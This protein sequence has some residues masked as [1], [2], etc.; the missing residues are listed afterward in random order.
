MKTPEIDNQYSTSPCGHNIEQAL[1]AAG[2]DLHHLK[3][4]DLGALE[5]IH[6]SVLADPAATPTRPP[7]PLGRR[8][9]VSTG[10]LVPRRTGSG[11]AK[12]AFVLGLLYAAV[13]AYWGLGGTWLLATVGGALQSQ[14]RAGT[15][16]VVLAV[17][18]AVVLKMVAA[19]LP[20]LALRRVTSPGG[21]RAVG[22]L[23]WIEA[24]ILTV[25]GLV[26]TAVGMLVQAGT[27]HP[28]AGADHRA[29]AW[30]AYL[31]DPWFLVWGL[32]VAIALW[33]GRHTHGQVQ[34]QSGTLGYRQKSETAR[35]A[36]G[37]V[38]RRGGDT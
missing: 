13:S 38:L 34:A 6:T 9:P 29:S 5:D 16:I 27:I 30:H 17:W 10:W 14:G 22:L 8:W 1:I 20:L 19:G 33:R 28:S 36:T 32:L 26:W 12:A 23:A 25:Y 31:W 37:G 24:G 21:N 15:A 3:A 7:G 2:E 4:A 18:A 11:A 35:R